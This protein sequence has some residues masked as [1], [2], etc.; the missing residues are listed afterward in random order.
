MVARNRNVI[1]LFGGGNSSGGSGG[2]AG[3]SNPSS[4]YFNQRVSE[5]ESDLDKFK[6]QLDEQRVQFVE[7][8]AVFVALFTFVS[9]DI[10]VFKSNIST[11]SAAGFTLIMFS[12]LISFVFILVNLIDD[13]KF[14]RIR[15][16]WWLVATAVLMITGICLVGQDYRGVEKSLDNKFYSKDEVDSA[17]ASSSASF[18]E[19]KSCLRSGKGSWFCANN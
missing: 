18:V 10:Q 8:L 15:T 16:R 6:D 17:I 2:S 11:L 7:T 14:K 3:T 4:D 9:V 5:L 12:A 1:T 13:K 19:F